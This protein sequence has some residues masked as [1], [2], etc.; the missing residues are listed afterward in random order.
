MDVRTTITVVQQ[1]HHVYLRSSGT[2]IMLISSQIK[3]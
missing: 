3:C 2:V 1:K